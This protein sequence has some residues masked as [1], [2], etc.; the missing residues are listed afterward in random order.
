MKIKMVVAVHKPYEVP[1]N[2]IYMPIQVGAEGKS[3][4]GFQGDNTG[5]NISFKNPY[6]C[7]LTG[8]YWAWKNL[9][10]EVIGLVHYRRYFG[11]KTT[12]DYLRD[13]ITPEEIEGCLSLY[14]IIVPQKNHYYIDTIESHLHHHLK[15]FTKVDYLGF[16]RL[17]VKET[18][19]EYGDSLEKCLKKRSGHMCNMFVMRRE[20]FCAYCEWLFLILEWME[21]K[22]SQY[23][24]EEPMQRIYGFLG[25]ILLD[26]WIDR[27]KIRYVEYPIISLEERSKFRKGIDFCKRKFLGIK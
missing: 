25:E 27:N 13:L 7:E 4:I 6:Y 1:D 20:N 26:V 3:T 15:L 12:D 21:K 16:L 17:A 23:T 14:D 19:P 2:N 5:E 10:A 22:H 11:K 24:A 18:W 8:I 9:E